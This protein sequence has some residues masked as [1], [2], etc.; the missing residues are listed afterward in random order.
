VSIQRQDHSTTTDLRYLDAGNVEHGSGTM[1]GI[2]MCTEDDE[3][4]GSFAG[5]LVEPASRRVRY[6]VVERPSVLRRR[7]Y[8]LDADTLATL[9]ETTLRVQAHAED[10]ERFDLRTVQSFSDEDLITTMFAPSAV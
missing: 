5:V 8:L 3:Q 6:F 7:R 2:Q 4:L 1:Q 10:L 9:D